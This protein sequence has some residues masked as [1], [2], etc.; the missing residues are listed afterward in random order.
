MSRFNNTELTSWN[1]KRVSRT[2]R[3]AHSWHPKILKYVWTIRKEP[4]KLSNSTSPCISNTM[5][6]AILTTLSLLFASTHS[7]S[8]TTSSKRS[9]ICSF[10]VNCGH[11][12]SPITAS[13]Y[14][15]TSTVYTICIVWT[16]PTTSLRMC[17]QLRSKDCK[18]WIV[19]SW[20]KID[21]KPMKA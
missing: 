19:L 16:Y 13:K 15:K 1:E 2:N 6:S 4:S 14:C 17:L 7:T 21:W 18:I 11:L 20:G 9:K 8:I 5:D 3:I 10:W 12:I